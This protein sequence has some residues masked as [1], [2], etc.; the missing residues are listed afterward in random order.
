[1]C[2]CGWVCDNA[3]IGTGQ[4]ERVKEA[5]GEAGSNRSRMG[6]ARESQGDAEKDPRRDVFLSDRHPQPSLCVHT[7]LVRAGSNV[8]HTQTSPG[9]GGLRQEIPSQP[10]C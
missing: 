8:K 6:Y 4:T 5:K 10:F 2:D 1:M 7:T 3:R 9:S